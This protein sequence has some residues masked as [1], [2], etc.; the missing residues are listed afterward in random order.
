MAAW[1]QELWSN[2][3]GEA[4]LSTREQAKMVG[5][6]YWYDSSRLNNLGYAPMSSRQALAGAISWLV[7]SGHVPAAVR[8]TIQLS[9][10]IYEIRQQEYLTKN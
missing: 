5:Q 7:S 2:I 3:S 8:S 1:A 6:Y 4:P 10:E 9:D